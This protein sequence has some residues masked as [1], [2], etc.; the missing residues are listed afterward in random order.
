MPLI[1]KW[2][3]TRIPSIQ[4]LHPEVYILILPA[5]GIVSQVIGFFSQKPIFGLTGMICAM[6]AISLLGFIVWAFL[7]GMGLLIRENQVINSCYMLE[8][9]YAMGYVSSSMQF[10][11]SCGHPFGTAAN[12][13]MSVGYACSGALAIPTVLVTCFKTVVN[14]A[15]DQS[16]GNYV[17]SFAIIGANNSARNG[18]LM[19]TFGTVSSSETI[20][21]MSVNSYR[22]LRPSWFLD[23]F[24]GFAEGDG[25][26][27]C[28]RN[29][30]RLY[31]Q[32]RQKDPKILYDIKA[33]FGFGT[34]VHAAD[35][36][37]TYSVSAKKDILV[38]LNIFN[39]K[40]VLTKTNNRFVSQW[41][42]NYNLWFATPK[43]LNPIAYK[44]AGSFVGLQNA[45]LCGF[46]DADGSI[47]FKIAADKGRK[48]GCRLRVYWYVDQ[49]GFTTLKDLQNMQSVLGF[50]YIEKKKPSNY[51]FPPSQVAHQDSTKG[52]VPNVAYRLITMTAVD[53]K[54]LQIYFTKYAPQTTI[55]K[56][57]FIRWNRVLNWCLDRVWF[58][59]LDEIKHLIRLN[60]DL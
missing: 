31:F 7:I 9:L 51:S 14:M 52:Y 40:L 53:C 13:I 30:K 60:Q 23:W 57:R 1:N 8:R 48:H 11:E 36:Y 39:G 38:L 50:C 35:G 16:A 29:A 2:Y 41:L 55:K 58:D 18:M 15:S 25:S 44:G 12:V 6:G 34:V 28:D 5:F 56:V 46:T 26:F 54:H 17:Y 45:W 27:S 43:G 3:L 32:L 47:G 24:V 4:G 49:N 22:G 37:Y 42:D 10:W 20:R 59:H 21:K 19:G 33:Y